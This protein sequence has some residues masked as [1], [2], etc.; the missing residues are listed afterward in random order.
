MTLSSFQELMTYGSPINDSIFH[1]FLSV[2]RSC[3]FHHHL[4]NKCW[5]SAYQKYF[6]HNNSSKYAE[7]TQFKPAILSPI[8]IIPIHANGSHWAMLTC[9]VIHNEVFFLYSDDL[10]F[11][12]TEDY[13]KQIYYQPME[14]WKNSSYKIHWLL[15]LTGTIWSN[16]HW[17]FTNDPHQNLNAIWFGGIASS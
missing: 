4:C 9:R 10:N 13:L 17:T 6:L 1:S 7:H 8:I 11:K 2:I 12:N 16:Y 5:M 3:H 15:S 14:G